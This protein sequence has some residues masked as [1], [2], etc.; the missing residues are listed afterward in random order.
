MLSIALIIVGIM[1]AMV[2]AG[3]GRLFLSASLPNS[4][5]PLHRRVQELRRQQGMLYTDL[6]LQIGLPARL[7]AEFE[8]GLHPL[9]ADQLRLVAAA[10]GTDLHALA[11]G[12]AAPS[13][14]ITRLRSRSLFT[15]SRLSKAMA[16]LAI[17]ILNVV[18]IYQGLP[19][20][21]EYL[22]PWLALPVG[23]IIIT[24][25]FWLRQRDVQ[26]KA[27]QICVIGTFIFFFCECY[28]VQS[29]YLAWTYPGFHFD[30]PFAGGSLECVCREPGRVQ[31][32]SAA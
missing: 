5:V 20:R 24:L 17:V 29:L 28:A 22:T 9:P 8:L 16:V 31:P 2:V 4:G 15:K 25:A 32:V 23:V 12:V 6:S 14:L 27:A 7:L 18:L 13:D 26:T 1:L 10:L 21:L 3:L 11:A 19:L 30:H